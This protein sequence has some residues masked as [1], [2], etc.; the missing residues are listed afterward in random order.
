MRK[1]Q[2]AIDTNLCLSP[3]ECGLCMQNCPQAV[4]LAVPLNV[5]KFRETPTEEYT[6]K[7]HSGW[8]VPGVG[9]VSRFA[10]GAP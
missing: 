6:L 3:L 9:N 8:T 2:I 4:F 7:P 10:R 1:G 5:Y